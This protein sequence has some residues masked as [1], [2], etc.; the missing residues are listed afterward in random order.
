MSFECF[1]KA[2]KTPIRVTAHR[3]VFVGEVTY[4]LSL[5][6]WLLSLFVV[7]VLVSAPFVVWHL[8]R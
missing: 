7:W 1:I 2:T 6:L 8:S 4:I 5:P 3:S